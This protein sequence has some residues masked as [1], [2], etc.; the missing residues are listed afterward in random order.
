[1][2]KRRSLGFKLAFYILASCTVIFAVI[3]VCNYF[4]SRETIVKNIKQCAKY[5]A[6]STVNK[7][8]SV[9]KPIEKVPNTV[10]EF[11]G[12]YPLDREQLQKLLEEIIEGNPDIYG[13]TVAFE[14]YVFDPAVEFYAPYCYR[15]EGKV[16]YMFLDGSTYKYYQWDWYQIPKELGKPI[17][18]E[19][20]F[21]EGAGNIL[22]A[23]YSVPIYKHL[24]GEK[25]LIGIV[26]AD[27]SLPWLENIVKSI[28]I[29]KT[30]YGFLLS[31][32]GRLVTHPLKELI[33]NE[34]I[35]DLAE[36][37]KDEKL[38]AIGKDMTRGKSGFVLT[39]SL[40]T[41]KPCWL[42]Y[43]PLPSIGWSLGTIYPQDELMEDLFRLNDVVIII[44]IG[45]FLFLLMVIIMISR[46]ITKPLMKLYQATKDIS[47]GNLEFDIDTI[48]SGDEVGKL[49]ESFVYMK[50]ALKKYIQELTET[51]VSKERMESELR[52]AHEIQLG[53]VPKTFPPFPELYELDIFAVLDPAKEVGGDFYDFFFLDDTHFCFVI[54]DVVGKGVPAALFMAVTKTLIKITALDVKET[55]IILSKVNKEICR[56]NIS[57]MFVTIFCGI[58]DIT[59]GEIVYTNSG[60]NP[61]FLVRKNKKIEMVRGG[62]SMAVGL[63]CDSMFAKDRLTL[64]PEDEIFLY[65]DGGTEAFNEKREQYSEA[66]LKER[67]ASGASLS[68]EE[69]VKNI[70]ND[71][72]SFAGTAEQS[73]DITLLALK[74][75]P[76]REEESVV[77][78]NDIQDIPRLKDVCARFIKKNNI[79][80]EIH[81]DINLALEE[82]VSNVI[83]YGFE[84]GKKHDIDVRIRKESGHI[85]VTIIDDGSPFDPLMQPKPDISRPVTERRQGGLGIFIAQKVMDD[86][87]YKREHDKNVLVMRKKYDGTN[88]VNS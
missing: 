40:S 20:Y 75:K 58:L 16:H 19:P 18:T 38:R 25:K 14:P 5:L 4:I 46:S 42:I 39:H 27:V 29:C 77:L 34:T 47:K 74:Y 10:A 49:A 68:A 81:E 60:H 82:V 31:K 3:F 41:G 87:Y 61:P 30:G 33:M 15:K 1:M 53:L 28:K 36:S 84:D 54:G 24:D 88:T 85:S 79:R 22:M 35:F 72:R 2:I 59:T 48:K 45:G 69:T 32:N 55:D 80:N 51:T 70:L 64:G 11:V 9:L 21:D 66:R 71:I 57:C 86:I 43:E 52:I 62:K 8:E 13:M 44:G 65:T 6:L 63:D 37:K 78:A 67:L 26:T 50:S 7:I 83:Y 12:S 17:W 73:D 56:D 76:P 23:T